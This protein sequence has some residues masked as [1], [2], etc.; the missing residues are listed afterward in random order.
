MNSLISRSKQLS[1]VIDT[2]EKQPFAFPSHLAEVKRE[3]LKAGDYA[4]DG[5]T[6]FAVERKSLNDFV[7]TI[8]SGWERFLKQ[9]MRMSKHIA[10]VIIVEGSLVEIIEARYNHPRIVPA[11]VLK[12]IAELTICGVSI[13]FADN[14][15]TA[16]GLC[17][18]ILKERKKEID[19][20]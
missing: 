6:Q 16:A 15:I 8:S 11:F 1:I 10:R 9:L 14:P 20:N 18:M 19:N 17:Y 13:L 2:R 12:R 3:T 7:G 5:D 4:L